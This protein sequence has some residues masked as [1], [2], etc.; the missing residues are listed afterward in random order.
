ML[1]GRESVVHSESPRRKGELRLWRVA[2][3]K[4]LLVS[5]AILLIAVGGW[6]TLA[7]CPLGWGFPKQNSDR[8]RVAHPSA[9]FGGWPR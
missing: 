8:W 7:R 2:R 9:L 4:L 1:R 3:D 5:T 6:P